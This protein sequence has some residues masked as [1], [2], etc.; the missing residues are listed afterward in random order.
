MSAVDTMC[1]AAATAQMAGRYEDAETLFRKAVALARL[2]REPRNLTYALNGLGGNLRFQGRFGAAL[3]VMNEH[4]EIARTLSG[5]DAMAASLANRA[6]LLRE[7][8]A[9][10]ERGSGRKSGLSEQA[11]L[12]LDEH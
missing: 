1:D 10:A 2:E 7:I 5:P 6:A 3:E 12:L 8:A 4:A 11:I 9:E